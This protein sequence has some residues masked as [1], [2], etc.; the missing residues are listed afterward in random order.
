MRLKERAECERNLLRKLFR[1]YEELA[2]VMPEVKLHK[3][4]DGDRLRYYITSSENP[5]ETY[6]GWRSQGELLRKLLGRENAKEKLQIL[7]GNL[8]AVE[9]LLR[10]WTPVEE[11][12]SDEECCDVPMRENR[13]LPKSQNPYKSHE[14]IHDTGL[15]FYTRSKSEAIV[16]RRLFAHGI[17]FEYEAPLRIKSQLGFWKTIYPDFTI[18]LDDGRV[19]YLEHVGK[20]QE[21]EYQKKFLNKILEYHKNDYLISRD[22]FITMDGPDG[23]I[24]ISAIDALIRML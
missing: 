12:F 13:Q 16:A 24:D 2:G 4:H 23:D 15:G 19:I 9:K 17:R 14:L 18:W 7:K 22:V 11:L 6:I 1:R 5:K 21:E 20:L 10:T 8:D 3:R